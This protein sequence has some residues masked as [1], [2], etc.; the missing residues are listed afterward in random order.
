MA[1]KV[2]RL[3]ESELKK[4]IYEAVMPMLSEIDAASYARVHNFTDKAKKNNQ[5]GDYVHQVNPTKQETNDSIIA[6]GIDLEPRAADS[7][8]K[9]YK[10]IAYMFYCRNLRQ[11]T[12][13]VLFSLESL[14]ELTKSKSVLKGEIV[15]NNQRM[16]GSIIIDMSSLQ[17]VY[18][19]NSSKKKYPLE[20]DN[21]FV[22]KWNELCF[23]LQRASQ[24]IP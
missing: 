6:H 16:N 13:I 24:M 7:M 22:Q 19:H 11:N 3:T 18:Y 23:T 21:R 12:G 5:Q 1:K 2:I 15:F 20:I 17:V 9:P 4:A 14:F 10:E 8:I